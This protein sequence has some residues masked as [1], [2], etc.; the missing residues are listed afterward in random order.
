MTAPSATPGF[1]ERLV[2]GLWL[3]VTL[4]LLLPAVG[5][6]LTPVAPAFAIP[7]AIAV[8]V[9]IAGALMLMAPIVEVRDGSLS[10]GRARIPVAQLGEVEVLDAEALRRAIGPGT[11]ARAYL[12]VRGYI[13]SGVRVAVQ[14]PADP[15]PYWVITT[16]RPK[17]LSAAI[18][19]AR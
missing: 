2:P 17:S 3:L 9:L 14:D 10:A 18:E 12:L 7:G 16:R 15:T 11:D 4:L 19:A 1:R 8:Y 6:I 5:L 13:H